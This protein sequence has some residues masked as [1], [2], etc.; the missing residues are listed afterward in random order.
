M[1]PRVRDRD[2]D[3][4]A[5]SERRDAL[6]RGV[7]RVDRRALRMLRPPRLVLLRQRSPGL[8]GRGDHRSPPGGPNLV[9]PPRLAR[10]TVLVPPSSARSPS[11]FCT[12][13]AASASR[14]RSSA[15][16]TS[17]AACKRVT[18]ELDGARGPGGYAAD[19]HRLRHRLARRGRRDLARPA[20][21]DPVQPDRP[22]TRPPAV[23]TRASR[24]RR[25]P[26]F[27]C[28]RPQGQVVRT[29]GA[30]AGLVAATAESS[31]QPD[32]GDHRHRSRRGQRRRR[33]AHTHRA[34]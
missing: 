29:L 14:R 20:G 31:A 12:A 2:A 19:R 28:S 10:A 25:A 34:A 26:R 3:A 8:A 16:P 27:S 30:G 15:P 5:P 18:A 11:R 24:A 22:R 17:G 1:S 4:R 9:G 23:S 21:R 13:S 33:R 7:R 6:R 32:L